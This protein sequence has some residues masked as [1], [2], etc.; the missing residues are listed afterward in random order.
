MRPI[1]ILGSDGMLGSAVL[2]LALRRGH[3]VIGTTR[4]RSEETY[5]DAAKSRIADVIDTLNLPEGSWVINAIGAVKSRM[6]SSQPD[7]RKEQI[8]V[9]SLFP[10]E[11]A[12]VCEQRGLKVLQVATDCVYSGRTGLYSERSSHDPT[13]I[14]GISKSLGEVDSSSTMTIRCSIVGPERPGNS[15]LLLE[16]LRSLPENAAVDGYLNHLW[17]GVPS[18]AMAKILLGVIESGDLVRGVHHLVPK[19]SLTKFELV[20]RLIDL[21]DRRDVTVNPVSVNPVDR[22]LSTLRPELNEKLFKGAGYG[23]VPDIGSLLDELFRIV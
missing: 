23:E 16:W 9:N 14:Y 7:V 18:N 19:N 12:S 11:L 3:Q 1:L 5:F 6:T 22:R 8:A 15:R 2:T 21:I 4:V 13:D 10:H 17:S 20:C